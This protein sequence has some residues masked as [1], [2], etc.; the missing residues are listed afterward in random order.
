MFTI[1]GN[2][3]DYVR[4]TRIDCLSYKFENLSDQII[5]ITITQVTQPEEYTTVTNINVGAFANITLPQIGA[6]K[7][8]MKIGEVP[9]HYNAVFN[10]ATPFTIN[11]IFVDGVDIYA[12][13]TVVNSFTEI[14]ALAAICQTWLNS[15][16]GGNAYAIDNGLGVFTISIYSSTHVWNYFAGVGPIQTDFVAFAAAPFTY[17]DVLIELCTIEAC[18]MQLFD[19]A[20]CKNG[21]VDPCCKGCSDKERQSLAAMKDQLNWFITLLTFGFS[22]LIADKLRGIGLQPNDTNWPP[23]NQ[24]SDIWEQIIAFTTDCGECPPTQTVPSNPCQSC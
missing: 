22:P 1:L 2:G 5:T 12:G 19:K 16:G 15:N 20:Y 23:L 11:A 6:Y 21:T 3:S 17:C 14:E 4:Y 8:C 10:F 18:F 7:V 24:V 13:S 9:Q